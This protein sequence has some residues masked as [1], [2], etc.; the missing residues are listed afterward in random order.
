[1]WLV[2]LTGT[3]GQGLECHAKAPGLD[4]LGRVHTGSYQRMGAAAF[5]SSLVQFQK[6]A[7]YLHQHASSLLQ[8]QFRSGPGY[9]L[10]LLVPSSPAMLY[11]V[12]FLSD[13]EGIEAVESDSWT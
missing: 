1:M 4:P 5:S 7:E 10:G 11:T 8:P 13:S 9:F 3:R 12:Q 2:R 6:L